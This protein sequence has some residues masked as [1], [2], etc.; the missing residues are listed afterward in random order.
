[1]KSIRVNISIPQKLLIIE[2]SVEKEFTCLSS[3]I[4]EF[5]TQEAQNVLGRRRTLKLVRGIRFFRELRLLCFSP[6]RH[7]RISACHVELT[8]V[9]FYKLVFPCICMFAHKLIVGP[10]IVFDKYIVHI[11]ICVAVRS[12]T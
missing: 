6:P 8:N 11:L 10:N 1:M 3:F 5:V 9:F 2:M 12:V 7:L 4:T